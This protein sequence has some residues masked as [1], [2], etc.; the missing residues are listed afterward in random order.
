MK[1]IFISHGGADAAIASRLAGDLRNAGHETVVDTRE[2]KLGDDAIEF[3]NQG[4]ADAHSPSFPAELTL[5]LMRVPHPIPYQGSKRNLAPAILG[6]FP[7]RV[8]TLIEPSAGSAALGLAS[9]S[10]P[11]S[12]L[13][14]RGLSSLVCALTVQSDSQCETHNAA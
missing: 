4:I 1:N 5:E 2:L 12:P 14:L 7:E 10:E 6:Y 11:A 9:A 13:L 3:M 8:G